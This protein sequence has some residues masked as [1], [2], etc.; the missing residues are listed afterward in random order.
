MKKKRLTF[1]FETRSVCDLKSSGAYKYSEDP[2]TRATCMAF[3]IHGEPTIYFLDFF[4][5][6][7]HWKDLPQKFKNLWSRLIE[8]RYEFSAHNV[9]FDSALYKNVLVKRQGWPDIPFD[10]FHCTAAKAAACALP[11]N[12]EGAGA[13]LNLSVQKDKRGFIAMMVTCKP[14]KAWNAWNKKAVKEFDSHGCGPQDP[15]PKLFLEPNDSPEAAEIFE[16]LYTYCKYDVLSEEALDDRLPDLIPIEREVWLLNQKLNWRGI[17]VDVKTI[18]KII[19][20]LDSESKIKL[21]ELDALTMGLVTK[22]GARKSILE[23]LALDGV[24]LPDIK[25]QTVQD[26]LAGGKLNPDMKKLLEIRKALSKSSVKK[27][28]AF[29]KRA[30]ED[31]GRVRDI[32]LYHGASTGRDSGTGIQIQNFPRGLI[33]VEK[34]RPYAAVENIIECDTETLKLLYGDDLSILFSAV[35]RNMIQ[36]TPGRELFAADFSKI[37]VAV[38]WW[39]ADNGP[40]LKVLAAGRDPYIYQA[41]A[42]LG[43]SYEEIDEAIKKDETWAKDARQLAKAQVLGCIGEGTLVKTNRGDL[44]IENVTAKDLLWDGHQWAKHEGLKSTGLKNVIQIESLNLSA[45]PDHWLKIDNAWFA[46]AEVVTSPQLLARASAV[47][48]SSAMKCESASSAVSYAAAFAELKKRLGSTN[49]GL[50]KLEPVLS[51]LSLLIPKNINQTEAAIYLVTR[52]FG[53]GGRLASLISNGAAII[54]VQK[55]SRGMAVAAYDAP[56]NPFEVSW[57]TLL[58]WTGL[59]NGASRWTELITTGT[60]DPETYESCLKKLTTKTVQ[61]Y[62]VQAVG[63]LN[64]YQAGKIIVHNC[65]FGMGWSKFQLTAHDVYRLKLGDK[66]S[67]EAVA[68]YREA[69]AAVPELWK[70]Y[71][72][73]AINAVENPGEIFYAGKC[74]FQ[75]ENGFLWVRLPGGRPLAYASPQVSWRMRDFE[76]VET[77]IDEEGKEVK[78]TRTE[79]RGPFKTLEFYAVN[80]KTKKW[81]LERTWGGSLTENFVQAM[82]RNLMASALLRLEKSGYQALFQVHDE[83]VC[84]KELGKGSLSEFIKIMCL[85]PKWAAGLPIEASGWQGPRYK[86]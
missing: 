78:T 9:F 80:S 11:R 21:K 48:K 72:Q 46:A 44:K 42:N 18:R 13:A 58:L 3:K 75:D 81:G 32:L 16:T 7:K 50:E 76:V 63:F 8:E 38:L 84:E 43:K 28:Q 31:D 24:E 83:I 60:I 39:A 41:A 20:I 53:N 6:G 34:A 68:S 27:Y 86:K 40:G 65:G 19:S 66:Q 14:T 57:N 4:T 62:D 29:I 30:S 85:K 36:A 15:A 23:F 47:G 10:L 73:A 5:I 49:C 17:R 45:T 35:L 77:S 69:N 74:E 61:T 37:E 12:L 71:E 1:D 52:V 51:V 22:P 33:K 82:A 54:N 67:R 64:Q 25:A 56:S 55:T 2:T 70:A 79:T 59:T 26:A